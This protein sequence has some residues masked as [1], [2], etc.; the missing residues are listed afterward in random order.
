MQ[1]FGMVDISRKKV[2]K[3]RAVAE[4]TVKMTHKAFTQWLQDGSPKGDV[5]SAA[6]I[7]GTMAAKK[8]PDLIPYCHPLALKNV[9]ID[10]KIQRKTSMITV[11]GEVTCTAQTGVEMEAMA[12]VSVAAL[13][14]YDMLKCLD[15]AMVI[16][17][18]RL[19]KKTGGKSGDYAASY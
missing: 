18:V 6:R 14:V 17:S 10:F 16:E 15:K 3:R 4:A 5:L 13:T 8:T 19:L 7:A 11:T 2:T 12:A 1:N 9:N